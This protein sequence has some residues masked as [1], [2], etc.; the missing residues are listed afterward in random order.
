MPLLLEKKLLFLP[1]NVTPHSDSSSIWSSFS[2]LLLVREAGPYF[3]LAGKVAN[4]TPPF[5]T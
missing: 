3:P 2:F 1:V 4:S 5:L